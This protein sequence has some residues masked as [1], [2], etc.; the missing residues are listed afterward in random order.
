MLEVFIF[1]GRL[2]L[3][4]VQQKKTPFA[5]G[6]SDLD[7]AIADAQCF[8]RYVE[9]IVMRTKNYRDRSKFPRRKS[10]STYDSYIF[11]LSKGMIRPDLMPFIPERIQ[12]LDFFSG[13]SR[14]Y[15]S[16]FKN[17]SAAVYLSD[18]LFAMKQTDALQSYMDENGFL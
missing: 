6:I 8:Q 1:A 14:K 13:L 9:T 10:E 5:A 4:L 7:V 17:I 15:R 12:W 11:Y 3:D 18:A 2:N 16:R